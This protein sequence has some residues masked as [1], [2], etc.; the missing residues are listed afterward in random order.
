M[1]VNPLHQRKG[2]N[3][4]LVETVA[5]YVRDRL[6]G[7][8]LIASYWIEE[9]GDYWPRRGFVPIPGA[10]GVLKKGFTLR[11]ELEGLRQELHSCKGARVL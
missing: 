3:M 4:A 6:G 7:Q 1:C 5:N 2:I 9:T 10:N 8:R 11:P